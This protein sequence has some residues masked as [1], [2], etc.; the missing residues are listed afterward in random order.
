MS[1]QRNPT[2]DWR[3]RRSSHANLDSLE[4]E[5]F[6][7]GRTLPIITEKR[8]RGRCIEDPR[9]ACGCAQAR[10]VGRAR[11]IELAEGRA[12]ARAVHRALGAPVGDLGIAVG[13]LVARVVEEAVG[14]A[15]AGAARVVR[16]RSRRPCGRR[17][18]RGRCGRGGGLGR[19]ERAV[20]AGAGVRARGVTGLGSAGGEDEDED[21]G[22]L[23]APRYPGP[24]VHWT[25]G[26]CWRADGP[27]RARPW[28]V[29]PQDRL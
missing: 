12:E 10:V 2:R 3:F 4:E 15:G 29:R 24:A 16:R 13:G 6:Q 23:H 26:S 9:D 11:I 27:L 20:G 7:I 18:R 25:T 1:S 28:G 14:L 19:A 17:G 21:R 5:A 8:A 22:W